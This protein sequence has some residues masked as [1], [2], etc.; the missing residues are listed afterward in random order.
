ME[1]RENKSIEVLF[2]GGSPGQY[3]VRKLKT[4]VRLD[5]MDITSILRDEVTLQKN[6]LALECY[7]DQVGFYQN[8]GLQ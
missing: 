1:I 8:K 4:L 7:D 3:W 5:D 6:L 2:W